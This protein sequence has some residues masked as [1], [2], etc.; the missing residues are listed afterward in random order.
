MSGQSAAGTCQLPWFGAA[1]GRPGCCEA[2]A[3][4]V[5]SS[6]VS[7]G[8]RQRRSS[9]AAVGL[10]RR[11]TT[12]SPAPHRLES[13]PANTATAAQTHPAGQTYLRLSCSETIVSGSETVRCSETLLCCSETFECCSETFVCCS[14]TFSCAAVR[15][16]VTQ[17]AVKVHASGSLLQGVHQITMCSVEAGCCTSGRLQHCSAAV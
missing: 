12:V 1:A 5:S 8:R 2:A 17:T 3:G 14:E 6:S 16:R 4:N 7:A 13:R 10:P 11:S 15:Q 9:S